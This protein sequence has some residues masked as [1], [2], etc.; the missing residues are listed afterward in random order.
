M[1]SGDI[2]GKEASRVFGAMRM[3]R[4]VRAISDH[5]SYA[6]TKPLRHIERK[7]VA[8]FVALPGRHDRLKAL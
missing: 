5:E 3:T 8:D 2:T 1:K 6:E 4:S 7:R